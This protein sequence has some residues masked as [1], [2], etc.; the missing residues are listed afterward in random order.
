MTYV[1]GGLAGLIY[2]AVFGLL[3]R[4]VFPKNT[5]PNGFMKQVYLYMGVS[6]L[7]NVVV[8]LSV[9][10]LRHLWPY[11]FEATIIGAAVGLSVTGKLIGRYLRR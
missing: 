8:L 4:L 1:I 7:I 10:F 11:S 2:G 3:K 9:Y 5:E 6:M